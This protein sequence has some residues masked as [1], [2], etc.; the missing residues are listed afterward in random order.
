M[1]ATSRGHSLDLG[2]SLSY[3]S[4]SNSWDQLLAFGKQEATGTLVEDE[5]SAGKGTSGTAYRQSK[6]A[7]ALNGHTYQPTPWL[8]E[9]DSTI[10]GQGEASRLCGLPYV[11][12]TSRLPCCDP[13]A[14]LS[15][16]YTSCEPLVPATT[17][18][19][20]QRLLAA[21]KCLHDAF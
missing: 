15:F 16:A 7:A 9:S 4:N 10:W 18:V 8:S 17:F 13:L 6:D 3:R 1:R 14:S 21:H 19:T 2:D 11:P 20:T 12:L 5:V